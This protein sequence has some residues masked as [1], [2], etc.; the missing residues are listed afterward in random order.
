MWKGLCFN[1]PL[2]EL[3]ELEKLSSFSWSQSQMLPHD[4][5]QK[6]QV[7]NKEQSR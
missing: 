7:R 2:H 6:L 5:K 3:S 4:G 1:S